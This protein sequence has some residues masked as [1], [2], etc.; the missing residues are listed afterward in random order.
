[1]PSR[2]AS[3]IPCTVA[4]A[5]RPISIPSTMSGT[6][7]TT[8]IN[9][10]A[11]AA[12]AVL[13]HRRSR[14]RSNSGQIAIA[15]TTAHSNAGRKSQ[16]IQIPTASKAEMSA[17]RPRRRDVVEP[18]KSETESGRT[19]PPDGKLDGDGSDTMATNALFNTCSLPRSR[20]LTIFPGAEHAEIW[21]RARP[22]GGP[23]PA[24]GVG[25][26]LQV[27]RSG[28]TKGEHADL[29]QRFLEDQKIAGTF[30]RAL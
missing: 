2:S 23:G 22:T 7:T 25:H 9:S 6:I 11:S 8:P 29:R 19:C 26:Q 16:T 13:F 21:N 3:L 15:T 5:S 4:T 30:C 27:D 28:P 1:M 20:S 14:L 24:P 12:A 18:A 17:N 10:V